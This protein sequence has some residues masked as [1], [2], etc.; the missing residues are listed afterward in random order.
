[1]SGYAQKVGGAVTQFSDTFNRGTLNP[2]GQNSWTHILQTLIP[3][4]NPFTY[5]T[6]FCNGASQIVLSGQGNGNAGAIPTILPCTALTYSR[7]YGQ[8]QFVQ[9]TFQ[10]LLNAVAIAAGLM[11]NARWDGINGG[12]Q[13]YGFNFSQTGTPFLETFTVSGGVVG[14]GVLFTAP[15]GQVLGDV[16]RL[17]FNTSTNTLTLTKNGVVLYSQVQAGGNLLTGGVPG[18]QMRTANSSAGNCNQV[19]MSNVSCGLGL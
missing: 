19:V 15:A 10:S 14:G 17:S 7:L 1:M 13:W 8:T 9:G 11:V 4:A 5:G 12:A 16:W 2:L 18:L 6:A 3:I